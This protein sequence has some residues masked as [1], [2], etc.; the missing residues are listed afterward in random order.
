M[1]LH[2]VLR[3]SF[4]VEEGEPFQ[5][6]RTADVGLLLQRNDPRVAVDVETT[7]A[8]LMCLEAQEAFDLKVR[9]SDQI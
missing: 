6:I 7:L 4:R 3:T 2:K 1:M 9:G 5:P 8:D